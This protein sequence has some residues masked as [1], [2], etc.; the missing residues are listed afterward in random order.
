MLPSPNYKAKT[1]RLSEVLSKAPDTSKAQ[2]EGFL[3][4]RKVSWGQHRNIRVGKIIRNYFC[5]SCNEI[6]TFFSGDSLSCLVTGESSVSVD[7]ALR[8]SAC[9][10]ATEAWFLVRCDDD[11]FSQAPVVYLE[12]YTENRRDMAGNGR[13]VTEQI[14][15]L[16]ER[17]QIAFDDHLGAGA[18][19]YLRKIFETTTSQAADAIGIA[20]LQRN[21]RRKNFRS[22]LEE[23]DTI[24]HI[25]PSE[26]SHNGYKLF[27]ELSEVIHGGS[28]E[29]EALRKYEPCRKLVLGIV[30]NIRNNQE[31]AQAVATLGWSGT[32][33]RNADGRMDP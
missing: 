11:L 8:C 23:V 21:G 2:V 16:L 29:V 20:I 15:D 18:M 25:I 33:I 26:F 3:G 32:T 13:L 7:V 28:D 31:M 30:N 10:A 17:A 12:R 22:L 9:L 24:S 27:S 5:L 6:R 4:Y 19:V 1:M 14:D